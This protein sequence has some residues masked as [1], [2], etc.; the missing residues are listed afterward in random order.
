MLITNLFQ[1]VLKIEESVKKTLIILILFL[2]CFTNG[3]NQKN[4]DYSALKLWYDKPAESWNQALPIGNGRLG[5]MV[6][7]GVEKERI[8]LNEES[9]W[10]GSPVERANPEAKKNLNKV[11]KLLFGGKYAEADK[12]AQEKIMGT[13]LERGVHTYQT[14]GNLYFEF[15]NHKKF[16]NYNRELDLDRAKVNI[17]YKIGKILY[18]REIFSSAPDNSLIIRLE[19]SVPG[20]ISFDITYKR[21]GE[22][23]KVDVNNNEIHLYEHVGNGNGVKLHS[24]LKVRI[25]GGDIWQENNK[26]KIE[27]ADRVYIFLVAATDYNN[28]DPYTK[29]RKY[30]GK[31]WDKPIEKVLNDHILDY[32]NLFR[33]VKFDLGKTNAVYFPVNQRIDAMK[34]GSEDPN[35]ISLYYQFGRYLLI[36]SS[37][38]GSLPANLQGIWAEGLNPPW[39]SDYHININIQMNYWPAEITNLSECHVPFFDFVENLIPR[40][41]ITAENTY[42]CRGFVAH[43]TTDLW[44]YTDVIGRTVYGMW[45]MGAAWCSDHFWE[46]F[47][48]T[49]DKIFLSERA[50]PVLKEAA[51]FFLD[52]L[53]KD[54]STGYLVS[55]PSISPENS[56]ITGDGQRSAICMGPAMDHQII[57]E[58]FSNTI[59]ASEVLNIDNRF[60][61]KLLKT[62][63]RLAPVK[64]GS[65]GRILEWSEELKE[66]EPGHRHMSHLYGLFP[67]NQFTYQNTPELFNAV[68]KS[69]NY[70]LSHGGGHTGWSRAWI[71]NFF[72]RLQDGN[73][74]Y[75]NVLAII[76][77][78]TLSNLFDNHPPF[79]IDGNFGAVAGISEM[80]LQSQAG[81]IHILPALP[82]AWPDGSISGLRARGG[83][84]VDIEWENNELKRL[85][86]FSNPG[87]QCKIRYKDKL[88]EINV[89]K[90]KSLYLN[91]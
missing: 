88:K 11:R 45:P 90:G 2:C 83:F 59:S 32:Q 31:V 20:S 42:G 61:K 85:R 77:K 91:Y 8:Q 66:A 22:M 18:K 24:I 72:A 52:F 76:R 47:L 62:L 44:Q 33:R 87:G 5:A 6:F 54:P 48:F 89:E 3:Q 57:R 28:E 69:I 38:Q 15:K 86:I 78:S 55:G 50:Y 35:L 58:L 64:I 40:G 60:R 81:E 14:L 26:L 80:L 4:P 13:R 68:K 75:E 12:L 43:H 79:Q 19:A 65:D 46:H 21:P 56:F 7:G 51:L 17:S 84:E 71:I 39:N 49:G 27:N 9:I 1:M 41:R 70:R 82:D 63:D 36:S 30:L 16:S 34:R 29:C 74:A 67:G 37:R 25:D 73:K 23:A 53:V 10:T